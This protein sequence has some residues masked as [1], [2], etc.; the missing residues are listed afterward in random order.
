[1]KTI[2][3]VDAL[4]SSLEVLESVAPSEH[5][6]RTE[7]CLSVPGLGR[8]LA[9]ELAAMKE[10]AVACEYCRQRV[11]QF[12]RARQITPSLIPKQAS[13]KLPFDRLLAAYWK[14]VL[15]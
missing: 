7:H 14:S 5:P 11:E 8:Y 4:Q 6:K 10:H 3:I 9:G 12:E 13:A 15:S 1:M 2:T